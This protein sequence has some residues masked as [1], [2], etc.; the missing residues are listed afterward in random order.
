MSDDGPTED[1]VRR[2]VLVRERPVAYVPGSW[3]GSLQAVERGYFPVSETGFRSCT[4]YWGRQ[5]IPDSELV[6]YAE[7][8]AAEQ[9]RRRADLLK[10]LRETNRPMD[11]PIA[12]YIHTS[13]VYEKAIQHGLF[14]EDRQRAALWSGAH[15]LL[16]RV[17]DDPRF[18]PRPDARH[19]AWNDGHCEMAR[20]GARQ[21]KQALQSWA[22]GDF[23]VEP[24]ARMVGA[25]AYFE[26]PPKPEGEPR[27][28]LGGYTR[29]MDL[30]MSNLAPALRR[31]RK[32][33][34]EADD[35]AQPPNPGIQLGLFDAPTVATRPAAANEPRPRLAP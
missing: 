4:G 29:E 31:H 14:A 33:E 19:P 1:G 7:S 17:E 30:E 9:D 26:L 8:V 15:R 10:L 21:L 20:R 34:A 27:I 25:S 32:A 16:C 22:A 12:N 24:P 11:G 18:Q 35:A 2:I 13:S 23:S 6:P 3:G 28:D 5:D